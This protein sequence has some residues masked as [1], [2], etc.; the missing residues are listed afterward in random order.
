MSPHHHQMF[1]TRCPS[2]DVA[3]ATDALP[4]T[5]D[6]ALSTEVVRS[7]APTM[8]TPCPHP[9]MPI[10]TRATNRRQLPLATLKVSLVYLPESLRDNQPW[11]PL[12][13]KGYELSFTMSGKR[14][15]VSMD[16]Q[17]NSEGQIH[18]PGM[19]LFIMAHLFWNPPPLKS[20]FENHKSKNYFQALPETYLRPI[21][22]LLSPS[23]RPN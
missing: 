17:Y 3:F 4:P 8:S 7:D 21:I 18:N 22:D 5:T 11:R 6:V 1:S 16:N 14:N 15:F 2:S 10:E 19:W 13:F 9:A 12:P 23:Q 20:T